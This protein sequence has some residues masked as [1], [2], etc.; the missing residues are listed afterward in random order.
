MRVLIGAASA[1][2][3]AATAAAQ[4][5]S[6]T[7]ATPAPPVPPSACGELQPAPPQPDPAHV[8]PAQMTHANQAYEAWGADMHAKLLCRQNEARAL[9]A[10][11][12]AAQTAYNAQAA[13]FTSAVNSWNAVAAA[14][15]AQHGAPQRSDRGRSRELDHN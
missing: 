11:A 6:T 2:L 7:P 12:Q 10:Q 8:T 1:L 14:Y 5:G 13:A 3:F 4:T 15:N 9:I